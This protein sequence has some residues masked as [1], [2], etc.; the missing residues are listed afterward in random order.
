MGLKENNEQLWE[1]IE[2]FTID[3]P[4]AVLK[5]S[6]KLARQNYWSEDYTART[7]SEYKKFIFLCCI[8]PNGASP[9]HD[10][11]EAWH[12]H[13]T[14]THNYWKEFCG[15]VLKKE[16]HH[17]PSTGGSN[18]TNKHQKWY[19][20]TLSSYREVFGIEPPQDIWP[21]L[22]VEEKIS[23]NSIIDN[24]GNFD[25]FRKNLYILLLPWIVIF[26]LYQKINPYKLTGPQFLVFYFSLFIAV[27]IF[28]LLVRSLKIKA[29]RSLCE[30]SMNF[31]PN[32]YQLAKFIYGKD[33]SIKAA[34]VDLAGR[35]ILEARRKQFFA[36]YP[37][38]Y[39]YS[40]AEKNPLLPGLLRNV[41]ENEKVHL[42]SI[43]KYYNHAATDHPLMA[44]LYKSFPGKDAW[45]VVTCAIFIAI[46]I[47][48]IMQGVNNDR[49]VAYLALMLVFFAVALALLLFKSNTKTILQ[50]LFKNNFN[51]K[52]G[53]RELQSTPFATR[54]VFGGV[55]AISAV[56]GYGYLRE[57]L[58]GKSGRLSSGGDSGWACG[59][60][61]CGSSCGS[62]C[63]GGGCGGCG[64]GD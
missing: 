60:S 42:N 19:S 51:S 3:D 45:P 30:N 11:D 46:G 6:H 10:V 52:Q 1:R 21:P 34:I 26:V 15:N 33:K 64:G 39:I 5:Y 62:S 57:S 14:Y 18:E 17:F 36:F 63:S 38:R 27:I 48:R 59:S 53:T 32:I 44:S 2:H 22:P 55:A 4:D 8:L 58:S 9:S 25:W 20:D 43:F 56:A 28:L 54:F 61:G 47:S 41:K 37:S 35:K 31:S 40:V 13:L 49:P 16:I 50:T 29:I 24:A 23:G 7:I 12:L